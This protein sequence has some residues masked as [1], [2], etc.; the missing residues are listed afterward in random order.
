MSIPFTSEKNRG[1]VLHGCLACGDAD[2]GAAG[3]GLRATRSFSRGD[4][5]YRDRP[6]VVLQSGWSARAAPACLNCGM[7]VGG[8]LR[9]LLQRAAAACEGAAGSWPQLEQSGWLDDEHFALPALSPCSAPD[10]LAAFCGEA[11]REAQMAS[12]HHRVLCRGSGCL[13][14]AQQD[15]WV[16]FCSHADTHYDTF[17]LAGLVICKVAGEVLFGQPLAQAIERL[18]RFCSRPWPELAAP[19]R[20][21]G[22]RVEKCMALLGE[23]HRLLCDALVGALPEGLERLLSYEGYSSLVGML[24][25]VTKDLARPNTLDKRLKEALDD[26]PVQL[27]TE[28]GQFGLVWMRARLDAENEDEDVSEF[29]GE[30]GKSAPAADGDA[31]A[32]DRQK[33]LVEMSRRAAK[34]PVLPGFEGFGLVEPVALTNHSCDAN[35]DIVP[36]VYTSDVVA[37]ATRDIAEGEELTMSYIDDTKHLHVRRHEL[38]S[39]YAFLCRCARCEAEAQL[40]SDEGGE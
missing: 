13:T 26:A 30:Q 19:G 32:G 28:L 14:A 38:L 31:A 40:A 5:I 18:T 35:T 4:I 36:S 2:Q 8:G 25:L 23:S 6:L 12:G 3:L 9:C 15:A 24:D 16:A 22:N 11:C 17:R 29:E 39:G 34:L 37:S 1:E 10:C 7:L 21:Q 20:R 33:D 27:R